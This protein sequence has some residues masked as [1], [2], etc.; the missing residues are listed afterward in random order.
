[1]NSVLDLT[2]RQSHNLIRNPRF[3]NAELLHLFSFFFWNSSSMCV[4][5]LSVKRE[6]NY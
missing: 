3:K 4:D 6:Q 1:M 2:H 5:L